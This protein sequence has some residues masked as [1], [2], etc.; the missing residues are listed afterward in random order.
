MTPTQKDAAEA[1]VNVFETGAVL[2]EYSMVTILAGDSG[3]FALASP[4][5]RLHPATCMS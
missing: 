2:G 4:R 3:H 5:R 1:I